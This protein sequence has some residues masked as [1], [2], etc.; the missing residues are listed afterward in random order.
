MALPRP[1]VAIISIELALLVRFSSSEGVLWVQAQ[2]TDNSW[3]LY[4]DVRLTGGFA[5]MIWFKGQHRGEFVLTLGGYHPDFHRDGYPVVPRL[6]LHWAIGDNIVIEAGSYFA[7]TSEAVMAGGDFHASAHFGPAWADLRFG[8][9]GIIYFDPFR[10]QVNAYVRISAGITIDTWIFGEITISVSLGA[11]IDIAGPQFHGVATFEVGPAGLSV[12]FGDSEQTRK[13]LLGAAQFIEK[14]LDPTPAGALAHAAMVAQGA[15]P[16]KGENSTPD[17]SGSRPFVVV[18]EFAMTF[19]TTVPAVEV[20]RVNAAGTALTTH[21]PSRALGVAPMGAPSVRPRLNLTWQRGNTP[22]AFPFVVGVRAFG[23][24]P[25][26][27]WG[28]PQPDDNR[29]VPKAD[30]IEA[31]NELDLTATATPSGGGPTIPYHQVEIG[32]RKPLPF[33]RRA[34]QVNAFKNE[35]SALAALISE[36]ATVDEAFGLASRFLSATATP[37]GLAALRG[38]RQ[39]PPRLGTL[40]EGLQA[41]AATVVPDVGSQPAAKVYDHF[42]DAPIAVGLLPGTTVD[43]RSANGGRTTVKDAPRLWQQ[44]PPTLASVEES[45]SRSIAARLVMTEPNAVSTGRRG[46]LIGA[47]RVPVTAIAHGPAAVVR[48]AGGA[49]TEHLDGF[50]AALTAGRRTGRGTAGAVL[51]AGETVVLRLPNAA[52][53]AGDGDR[54]QLQLNG[55]PARVVILAA[56]GQVMLDR[57]LT[58]DQTVEIGRGAERIV[59]IG[60]GRPADPPSQASPGEVGLAGWHAGAQLPYAGWSTALGPG[61]VLRSNG[62]PL[63]RNGERVDAGWVVGAELAKGLSTVTTSFAEP[64]RSVVIILDDPAALGDPVAGRG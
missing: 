31:L 21:N 61:C 46:T 2:L 20:N 62:D 5:F 13:E 8:A 35:T 53:D 28:P 25:V 10:Y 64:V 7:L 12:P 54:P 44:Q 42:V 38:E 49:G 55:D 39:A 56:G 60:Q 57:V 24:F 58:G 4:P 29:K 37:T 17:G 45:R 11:R 14:Y 18:C 50:S 6:G 1:Q 32:V 41:T 22:V 43:L 19:A 51:S 23:A 52:A 16:A 59:A 63:R 30:M 34:T 9:H 47:D 36:P 26:G 3:L 27:V 33:T 15:L 40:G 48:R